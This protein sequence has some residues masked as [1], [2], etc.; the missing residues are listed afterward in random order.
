MN[1]L[2]N[3]FPP[4]SATD[5][6]GMLVIGGCRVDDLAAEFGTPVLVV[7]PALIVLHGNW[8]TLLVFL[9]WTA[10]VIAWYFAYG[11]KHSHLGRHE[12]V[13][14]IKDEPVV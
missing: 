9:V 7:D 13:G 2:L 4:G 12:H 14:L 1:Q 5:A 10:I 11:R 6:D 3:L 8:I